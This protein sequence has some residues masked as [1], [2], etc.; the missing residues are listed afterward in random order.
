MGSA[1]QEA[2]DGPIDNLPKKHP[3]ES[4]SSRLFCT[5]RKTQPLFFNGSLRKRYEKHPGR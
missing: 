1:S 4:D 2:I 5:F 3:S